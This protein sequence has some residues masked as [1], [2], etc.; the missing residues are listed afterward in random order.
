MGTARAGN[1]QGSIALLLEIVGLVAVVETAIMLLLPRLGAHLSDA[2]ETLIDVCILCAVLLPWAGWRIGRRTGERVDDFPERRWRRV[3]FLV[4]GIG[5]AAACFFGL[6]VHRDAVHDRRSDFDNAVSQTLMQVQARLQRPAFGINGL[7][8]TLLSHPDLSR[9]EF[10]SWVAHRDLA[11]EFPGIRGFGL[12]QETSPEDSATLVSR[13]RSRGAEGFAIRSPNPGDRLYP[14]VQIEPIERNRAAL[15]FDIGSEAHRLFAARRALESGTLQLTAPITLVQD[16]RKRMGALLMKRTG[17]GRI[18]YAP[19]VYADLLAELDSLRIRNLRVELIDA[20]APGET[21]FAWGGGEKTN[22]ELRQDTLETFG[23]LLV[24]RSQGTDVEGRF[25]D[26]GLPIACLGILVSVLLGWM[27]ASI[28]GARERAESRY[29]K[30][31]GDLE[32]SELQARDALREASTFREILEEA[33]IISFTDRAG[34]ITEVNDAFCAISGYSRGE[35]IGSSHRIVRSDAQGKEFWA[36]M[37]GAI[38]SGRIWR[39]VV[40]NRRKDGADYWVDSIMAPF[41]DEDGNIVRYMS[42]RFDVTDRMLAERSVHESKELL[43]SILDSASSFGV[44][45]TDRDGRVAVFSKG[46]EALVGHA[47]KDVEFLETPML[48][49]DAEEVEARRRELSEVWGREL[50]PFEAFVRVASLGQIETRRWTFRRKDGTTFPGRLSVCRI[51]DGQGEIHGYLDIFEDITQELADQEELRRAKE[52]AEDATRAKSRF[53]ANMSHEIRTPMNGIL[54]VTDMLLDGRLDP[55]QKDLARIVRSSAVQLLTLLNDILD[56]SKI[57]AGKLEIE[58][59]EFQMPRLLHELRSLLSIKANEKGIVLE[60]KIAPVV[61][62]AFRG[63]PVRIRQVLMNLIGNALKFTDKGGVTVRLGGR[64]EGEDA[65]RLRVEIEDTGIGMTPRQVER[66]FGEYVQAEAGTAGK[67]GGTG[68]GLAISRSLVE[69]MGGEI[70][71]ESTQGKGTLFWFELSL[72]V[73]QAG[74]FLDPEVK[75]QLQS[76]EGVRVL[77]ADDNTVNLMVA[78][79]MLGKLGIVPDTVA[80]G[81]AALEALAQN[82]F[83]LVLMDMHMN[84]MDGPAATRRLRAGA[85]SRRNSMIPVVA[86]TAAATSDER[87]ICRE[88]GMN[89]HLIKPYMMDDL[90]RILTHWLPAR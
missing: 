69:L 83:D 88:A 53:L 30:V 39:G 63:D 90:V 35:L 15:G 37:W 81:Q 80:S 23:R 40:C 31:L 65:W 64:S 76:F 57:E 21:L 48:W 58:S 78:K 14:I 55:D 73:V 51:L 56:S 25:D 67:Y 77:V 46:A 1:G 50:K 79:A 66:L 8:A 28:L 33:S 71:V 60:T 19:L 6:M 29:R 87:E 44:V 7:A 89:E 32:F 82:D 85:P 5:T 74:Q 9:E 86:L 4:G 62:V 10:R 26:L 72:P 54:G 42:I 2:Q 75:P 3:P 16:D 18:V 43:Q 68:L 27:S 22:D 13:I 38:S 59:V 41:R 52:V 70:G 61:P 49:H 45:A 17:P 34:R 84:D 11:T 47:P 12:I 20:T 24:V 36:Q